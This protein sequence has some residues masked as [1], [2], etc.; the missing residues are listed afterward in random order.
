MEWIIRPI[1]PEDNQAM[2]HIIRTALSEF[3]ANKPG[4]VFFDSSTDHL[5]KLF[6]TPGSCYFV[7][8]EAVS[9]TGSTPQVVGGAGIFPTAGLPEGW[10]ELVKMYLHKEVRGKGL[11]RTLI[12]ESLSA[13]R[14]LGYRTVYL[15]TLPELNKAVRVYEQFGFNYLSKPVGDSGHFGCNVWMKMDL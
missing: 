10:C 11:G 7:A 13:A 9:A 14:Q 6:Q 4:T 2:A 1:Q 3:G 8:T 15:E 5:F 12:E